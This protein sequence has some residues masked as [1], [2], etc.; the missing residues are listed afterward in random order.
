MFGLQSLQLA[1][2]PFLHD[3]KILQDPFCDRRTISI[4]SPEPIEAFSTFNPHRPRS[5]PQSFLLHQKAHSLAPPSPSSPCRFYPISKFSQGRQSRTKC[6][7]PSPFVRL[8]NSFIPFFGRNCNWQCNV[9]SSRQS[10]LALIILTWSNYLASSKWVGNPSLLSSALLN[11]Q[12]LFSISSRRAIRLSPHY[13]TDMMRLQ[14][15]K[16][17]KIYYRAPSADNSITI[18]VHGDSRLASSAAPANAIISRETM[19]NTIADLF[20]SHSS[21]QWSRPQ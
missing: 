20:H 4:P 18:F 16:L 14:P 9:S 5:L 10:T 6:F 3:T 17:V 11:L 7:K 1:F 8:H 13:L 21:L 2:L 15:S 12:S 19:Q